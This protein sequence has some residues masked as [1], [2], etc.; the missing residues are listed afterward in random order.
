MNKKWTSIIY[1]HNISIGFIDFHQWVESVYI[2][3]HI[4]F[5]SQD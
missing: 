1:Y 2:N 5:L 4:E 3:Q